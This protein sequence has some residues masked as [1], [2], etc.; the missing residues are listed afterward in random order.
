MCWYDSLP[1]TTPTRRLG[2]ASSYSGRLRTGEKLFINAIVFC[3][4]VWVLRSAYAFSR[5]DIVPVLAALLETPEFVV[6]DADLA[7]RAAAQYSTGGAD[8]AD[9]FLGRRNERSGCSRTFT[10]DG[11]LKDDPLFRPL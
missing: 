10:L 7:R 11:K 5:D 8:L 2:L 4:L 1:K 6:E 9:Y 3:E